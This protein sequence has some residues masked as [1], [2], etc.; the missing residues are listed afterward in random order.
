MKTAYSTGKT[1][2]EVSR[3]LQGQ[4]G[5][6]H[7][8]AI[9]F[10]ASSTF[11]PDALGLEIGNAFDGAAVF[12]C[13]TA[14]E[15]VSGKMLKRSVVAMAFET[16]VIDRIKL[17]VIEDL[18]NKY[19]IDNAFAT[20][21]EYFGE[22]MLDMDPGKY[23]GIILAD[24]LSKVEEKLMDKIGD[25]TNVWFVGG[26]AGDDLQFKTTYVFADGNAYS[27]SA[28][29]ALIKPKV[30]FD[31]I[32][33][34]SFSS[35]GK[36]LRATKVDEF[37]REVIEFDGKPAIVAYADA[38]GSSV[39]DAPGHFMSQPVGLM[40]DDEPYVRSPQ[41]VKDGG[42]VF[43]CNVKEGTELSVLQS[44]DIV[45]DTRKAIES[46]Q[47]EIG[48]IGGII[49]FHCILRTL[50]LENKGQTEAYG[51]IFAD[52]PTIGFSTYGEQ[53]VGHMNQTS[54]MLVFKGAD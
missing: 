46:R 9:L 5:G 19:A 21:E 40:V 13:T 48:S 14:G 20:F 52:I 16:E 26:S 6:I 39:K 28:V 32:K 22:S 36:T 8:R 33:T 15:I 27:N 54:A 41:Q 12:G 3:D 43:Y 53:C 47:R 51:K 31:I 30:G 18:H 25:L 50:E 45:E 7:L 49:N 10:F 38:I 44:T 37:E 23:V 29:L 34:Q 2:R 11:D 35:L 4:L 17:C 1:I 42:M 24:G